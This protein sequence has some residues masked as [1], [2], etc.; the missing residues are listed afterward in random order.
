MSSERRIA[1][2]RANGRKTRG[3]VTPEGKARSAA[4]AI[5]HGL[6]S[7]H[8]A[9]Y[10]TCLANESPAEFMLLYEALVAEFAPATAAEHLIIHEMAVS[11]WRLHRNWSYETAALDH[12]M[13][14]MADSIAEDYDSMDETT[15]GLLA[16]RELT[17]RG[18]TLANL[19]RYETRLT[20]HFDRCLTRL[21][22]LQSLREKRKFPNNPSPNIEHFFTAPPAP[23][24]DH[25]P[26]LPESSPSPA[27]ETAHTPENP[28]E[29]GR[30]VERQ[31]P[32]TPVA[33]PTPQ[34]DPLR[35]QAGPDDPHASPGDTPRTPGAA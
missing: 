6:A 24:S 4:N 32:A 11:R 23:Q 34:V 21:A 27:A 22:Q 28:C 2:S 10:S 9:C 5:R 14:R 13:D 18:A 12:Q 29:S 30:I 17:E 20:R 26:E 8:R 19:Q 15:R 16:Y 33:P 7:T 25:D 35:P 3:P 31:S 1:A